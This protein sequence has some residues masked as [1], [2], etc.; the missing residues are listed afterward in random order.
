MEKGTSIWKLCMIFGI[1]AVALAGFISAISAHRK[2]RMIGM[3]MKAATQGLQTIG[4]M[5]TSHLTKQKA[6]GKS[7]MLSKTSRTHK[8][9]SVPIFFS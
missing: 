5:L 7:E 4:V 1:A 6:S 9:N 2:M 8:R 3:A